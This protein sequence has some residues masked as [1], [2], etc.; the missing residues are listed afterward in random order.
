ML[1]SGASGRLFAKRTAVD[2]GVNCVN[3]GATAATTVA[4][5]SVLGFG[6]SVVPLHAAATT[7]TPAIA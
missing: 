4:G 7:I 3:I 2:A 5:A 1:K 6:T